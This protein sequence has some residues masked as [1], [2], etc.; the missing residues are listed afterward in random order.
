[1]RGVSWVLWFLTVAFGVV[2]VLFLVF[3]R[4][5]VVLLNSIGI[6]FGGKTLGWAPGDRFWTVF[7]FAYMVLV[8]VLAF[9]GARNPAQTRGCVFLL[10]V[11]K[12]STS[13]VALGFFVL[14]DSAFALLAT[15][16]IDGG[17]AGVLLWCWVVLRREGIHERN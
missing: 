2:A 1:M 15:F 17:I 12:W 5:L 7:A 6:A 16:L 10:M 14:T 8:T 4:E 13:L 11:A 3:P 9:V